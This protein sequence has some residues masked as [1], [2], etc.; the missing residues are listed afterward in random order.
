M[1][2]LAYHSCLFYKYVSLGDAS[3]V[4]A[5]VAWAHRRCDEL[6]VCGRL[7]V[8]TEGVNGALACSGCA[9]AGCAA[10]ATC[11]LRI[12]VSELSGRPRLDGIDWKYSEAC[13]PI[14]GKTELTV[15][16]V[17]EIV[18]TDRA[19]VA[20]HDDGA[21][22]VKTGGKHLSP[23]EF[24]QALLEGSSR[25]SSDGSGSGKSGGGGK[26]D[27]VVIDVRNTFEHAIGT[28]KARPGI[29]GIDAIEPKMRSFTE[30]DRWAQSAA[31]A[32]KGKKVLMFCT[33]GIR[34]E[35]ASAMLKQRGVEDVSQLSGGIHRYLEQF[36]S[37]K[38]GLFL[39]RNFVFDHRVSVPSSSSSAAG[40]A[41]GATFD[42]SSSSVAEGSAGS[43]VKSSGAGLGAGA[44]AG[45]GAV[46][47][48]AAAG[49]AADVTATAAAAAATAAS[50]SDPS[51]EE[52]VVGR[53]VAPG[54][55]A[56]YEE[57]SGARVCA[58]CRDFVLVCPGCQTELREYHCASHAYLRNCYFSFF[59]GFSAA[60]LAPMIGELEGHIDRLAVCFPSKRKRKADNNYG[61]RC[62]R[63]V[64]AVA[65]GVGAGAGTS[66][67]SGATELSDPKG[68][69]AELE[70]KVAA[71]ETA[72][73][74]AGSGESSSSSIAATTTTSTSTANIP[75]VRR[76]DRRMLRKQV[77]RLRERKGLLEAKL[78]Q[79]HPVWSRRGGGAG[80]SDCNG[81]EKP[82]AIA[83]AT[84]TVLLPNNTQGWTT[85]CRSCGDSATAC[86]ERRTGQLTRCA[87]RRAVAPPTSMPAAS[88]TS[89]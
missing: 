74:D 38:G 44:G 11:P 1:E 4:D 2:M 73:L 54:C 59:D 69:A 8:G 68:A 67:A 39:G 41:A 78:A 27:T 50:G 24:H 45:A 49:G 3:A 82:G 31:P 57:L 32:L 84:S 63:G 70:T 51:P 79:P 77:A 5:L 55:G 21:G 81:E 46:D 20:M 10:T 42:A 34:C 22:G 6:S 19:A 28:F 88:V 23:E 87:A 47:G 64:T 17:N 60:E 80:G 52:L 33:G 37:D 9:G 89:S 86:S 43:G 15:K 66:A 76:D 16:R 14:F 26:Q 35:K 36:P 62:N 29:G 75:A 30:Y 7:L 58:V 12:F 18:A 53:C 65:A 56:A 48:G 25:S 72:A 61:G 13:S 71:L 85:R 83:V 40:A